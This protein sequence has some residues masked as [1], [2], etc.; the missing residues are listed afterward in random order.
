WR[1]PRSLSSGG[2]KAGT[3]C[4]LL[5]MKFFYVLSKPYAILRVCLAKAGTA[6][7]EFSKPAGGADEGVAQ[8]PF[9]IVHGFEGHPFG[10]PTGCDPLVG[11]ARTPVVAGK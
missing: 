2:P 10:A 9:D 4:G 3:G 8:G 11:V 6:I 1:R 5:R 7:R